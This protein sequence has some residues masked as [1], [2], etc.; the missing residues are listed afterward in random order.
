MWMEREATCEISL[1]LPFLDTVVWGLRGN[2]SPNAKSGVSPAPLTPPGLFQRGFPAGDSLEE[3]GT[4]KAL[5]RLPLLSRYNQAP[6][7]CW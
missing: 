1:C 7:E 4:N 5:N 6:A 3:V 2:Q